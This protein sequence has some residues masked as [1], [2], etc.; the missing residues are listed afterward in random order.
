MGKVA[1]IVNGV[2]RQVDTALQYEAT[3][4]APS[5]G[6]A[7]GTNLTLPNGG[8]Y[9]SKDLSVF[10]NGQLLEVGYDYNYVGTGTRTQIQLIAQVFEGERIL[11][12]VD[13]F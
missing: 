6:Y 13:S 10:L 4:V 1:R 3:I 9:F 2:V 5:G 12:R 8:T 7:S 11:Y